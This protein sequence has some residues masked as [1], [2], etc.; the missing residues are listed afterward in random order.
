MYY[1]KLTDARGRTHGPTY[2][3]PGVRHEAAPGT[4]RLC[5]HT[6][7]HFYPGSTLR[8]AGALA[9]HMNPVQARF[10]DP[11]AWTFWPEGDTVS[12]G[13]QSGCKA[14]TTLEEVALP[15][16][17]V[18]Q[19]V[20]TALRCTMRVRRVKMRASWAERW[21]SWAER[22]LSGEDRSKE[23]AEAAWTWAAE[24][25]VWAA[26]VAAWAAKSAAEE[27]AEAAWAAAWTAEAA[28]KWNAATEVAE[29][30][31]EVYYRGEEAQ[32]CTTSS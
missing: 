19:R 21:L 32:E 4:P 17:T 8:E 30:A 20:E 31:A 16:V 5:T 10:R 25:S 27:K 6:V 12:D 26:W 11:R 2:W 7:I 3:G 28:L 1:V 23:A 13:L 22:W 15:E 14:G 9:V 29:I 18:E 24:G